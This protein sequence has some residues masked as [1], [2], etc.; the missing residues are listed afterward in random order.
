MQLAATDEDIT[1]VLCCLSGKG[2]L[3]G[4]AGTPTAVYHIFPHPGGDCPRVVYHGS[5]AR[6]LVCQL[7]SG[8]QISSDTEAH[9]F[10]VR[11]LYTTSRVDL[12]AAHATLFR[13]F[14]HVLLNAFE[15]SIR[16]AY[17]DGWG[18]QRIIWEGRPVR[19]PVSARSYGAPSDQVIFE[20][21]TDVAFTPV[22]VMSAAPPLCHKERCG[23]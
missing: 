11:G 7:F 14:E 3:A 10:T 17:N 9:E 20:K 6:C 1:S 12:A 4:T 19:P 23:S 22:I 8:D 21:A 16:R 18:F 5:H 15:E 13:I 2:M